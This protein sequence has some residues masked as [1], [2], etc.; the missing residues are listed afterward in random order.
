MLS[1]PFY[2]E[3]IR[4]GTC[5]PGQH[6][7]IIDQK[8]WEQVQQRMARKSSEHKTSPGNTIFCPLTRR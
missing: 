3:Q 8:L 2:I 7:A 1:S 4:Q 6:K 5:Y